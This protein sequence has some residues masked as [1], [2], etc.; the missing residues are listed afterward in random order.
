MA[1]CEQIPKWFN[2]KT[3]RVEIFSVLI[4]EA[5]KLFF[6][7]RSCPALPAG[8]SLAPRTARAAAAPGPASRRLLDIL[9][10]FHRVRGSPQRGQASPHWGSANVPKVA[11]PPSL[12]LS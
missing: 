5:L 2:F 10:P 4:F 3:E 8:V 11:V 7:P 12:A 1:E 9:T 6:P